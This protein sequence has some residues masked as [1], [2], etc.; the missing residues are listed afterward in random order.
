[1]TKNEILELG[2]VAKA[3]ST[4][5]MIKSHPEIVKAVRDE[6][7]AKIADLEK[8]NAEQAERIKTLEDRIA[9]LEKTDGEN[10][11]KIVALEAERDNWRK[12]ALEEDAA[13]GVAA[14][15]GAKR[16]WKGK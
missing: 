16:A 2:R 9:Q 11:Q 14:K 4:E 13:A 1:M 5:R 15:Q 7:A 6:S 10:V 8:S 3:R 12:Q